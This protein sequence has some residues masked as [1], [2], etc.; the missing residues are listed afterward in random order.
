MNNLTEGIE[1]MKTKVCLL[2]KNVHGFNLT[3]DELVDKYL[4]FE[5]NEEI[6]VGIPFKY[7]GKCYSVGW[8]KPK[9]KMAMAREFIEKS[10]ETVNFAGEIT[11]PYCENVSSNS[12]AGNSED[13][14]ICDICGSVF[15]WVREIKEVNY[16]S[17]PIKKFEIKAIANAD[18]VKIK[19]GE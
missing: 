5:T 16:S 6:D 9:D 8:T 12:W 19:G 2:P 11:C 7:K 3:N 14:E 18:I 15:S 4:L 13:K 1:K 10:G 17:Q